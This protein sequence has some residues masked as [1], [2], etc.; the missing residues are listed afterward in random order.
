M[1]ELKLNRT[2]DEIHSTNLKTAETREKWSP[3]YKKLISEKLSRSAK[4]PRKSWSSCMTEEQREFSRQKRSDA[5]K[6]VNA[7]RTKE[8]R[9][10]I[11]EKISKA[12]KGADRNYPEERR[13]AAIEKQKQSRSA[14][15]PEQKELT[16]LRRR[17]TLTKKKLDL[18]HTTDDGGQ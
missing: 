14:R 4:L 7:N 18:M 13:L 6:L 5:I 9:K 2:Q 17:E 15:T 16:N 1:S 12:L 10:I 3:E 8:E 11:N